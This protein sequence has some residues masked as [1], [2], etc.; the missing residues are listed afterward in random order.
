MTYEEKV[1]QAKQ[2]LEESVEQLA[3]YAIFDSSAKLIEHAARLREV[4]QQYL[5]AVAAKPK[6]KLCGSPFKNLLWLRS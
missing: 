2:I 1:A 6:I 3:F 4:R 5:D